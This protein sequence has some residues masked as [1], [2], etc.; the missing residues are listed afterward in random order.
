MAEL[1]SRRGKFDEALNHLSKIRNVKTVSYKLNLKSLQLRL[2]YDAGLIEQ[3]ISA[4]D[5]FRHFIQKESLMNPIYNEQY[6]N[7]YSYYLKL[8]G[9]SS[10]KN[11]NAANEL[12][13]SL[14]P[15][16]NV[17]H[18]KWLMERIT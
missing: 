3:A 14:Q 2:Y 18:K 7:F 16:K 12:K 10:G 11:A 4:A 6:R 13:E 5:S 9:L 15:V 1:K 17:I 8:P